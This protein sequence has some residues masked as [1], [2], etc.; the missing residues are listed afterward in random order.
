MKVNKRVKQVKLTTSGSSLDLSLRWMTLNWSHGHSSVASPGIIVESIKQ[1]GVS[2][3]QGGD[4]SQM[5]AEQQYS[6]QGDSHHNKYSEAALTSKEPDVITP[7]VAFY[8]HREGEQQSKMELMDHPSES[9]QVKNKAALC[10]KNE[11]NN[12]DRKRVGTH[13]PKSR[14]YGKKHGHKSTTPVTEHILL[15]LHSESKSISNLGEEPS[16]TTIKDSHTGSQIPRAKKQQTKAAESSP[17]FINKTC[18]DVTKMK[19]FEVSDDDVEE[20]ENEVQYKKP[21]TTKITVS[22][23]EEDDDEY[24]P[25]PLR[26]KRKSF[27]KGVVS[28]TKGIIPS[29]LAAATRG[30]DVDEEKN[31]KPK[32]KQYKPESVSKTIKQKSLYSIPHDPLV[33]K[34][35]QIQGEE[36]ENREPYSPAPMLCTTVVGKHQLNI[37]TVAAPDGQHVE[38]EN[39]VVPLNDSS[40]IM[41]TKKHYYER[42]KKVEDREEEVKFAENVYEQKTENDVI[43]QS[44]KGPQLSLS[45]KSHKQQSQRR[46]KQLDRM[47]LQLLYGGG[48]EEISIP[49][50][51]THAQSDG[52]SDLSSTRGGRGVEFPHS[53]LEID[54]EEFGDDMDA[55]AQEDLDTLMRQLVLRATAMD[56]QKKLSQ[57]QATLDEGRQQA[58]N[59]SQQVKE[60]L[61]MH[62][63][64]TSL[65]IKSQLD[66]S[67]AQAEGVLEEFQPALEAHLSRKATIE[68]RMD[69]KLIEIQESA[70]R[71]HSMKAKWKRE[72]EQTN[73]RVRDL[74]KEAVTS[75]KNSILN[76]KKRRQR[77]VEGGNTQV[78]NSFLGAF[79]GHQHHL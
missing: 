60:A 49:R 53:E 55:D 11:E 65:E 4:S 73:K 27:T 63:K 8:S 50:Y 9:H 5:N 24:I 31:K 36:F 62:W 40:S 61:R 76:A 18:K 64:A 46:Q 71:L 2:Q 17:T 66:E 20:K 3:S 34:T 57:L 51:F 38:G 41:Q 28:A 72:A 52:G 59:Y 32:P 10:T 29:A 75:M 58:I 30:S 79:D 13:M 7:K 12:K 56:E 19:R 23:D 70:E 48:P 74:E 15:P 42:S 47:K 43:Y 37:I 26:G 68:A 77:K 54:D 35:P 33:F 25:S 69:E 22:D 16:T 45:S 67:V 78:L 44:S 6:S 39:E 1:L 14:T 21:A